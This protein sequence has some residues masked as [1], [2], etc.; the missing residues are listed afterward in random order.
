M[1]TVI[2]IIGVIIIMP[3][4]AACIFHAMLRVSLNVRKKRQARKKE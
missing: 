2:T 4:T 1:L 3:I